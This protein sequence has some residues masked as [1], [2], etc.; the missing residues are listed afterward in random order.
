MGAG[1]REGGGERC[2]VRGGSG[3]AVAVRAVQSLV[4]S[5]RAQVDTCC[6]GAGKNRSARLLKQRQGL[7]SEVLRSVS[8]FVGLIL[9]YLI[10]TI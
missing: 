8:L 5:L 6:S 1:G 9:S 4:V 7:W 2:L 10:L 3:G